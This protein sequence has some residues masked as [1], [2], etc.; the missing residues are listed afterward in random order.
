MIT[1]VFFMH[2]FYLIKLFIYLFISFHNCKNKREIQKILYIYRVFLLHQ[3]PS[4]EKPTQHLQGKMRVCWMTAPLGSSCN[5]LS[6]L[7]SR[8][9]RFPSGCGDV[10]L[11][12][13][14]E[15]VWRHGRRDWKTCVWTRP[16]MEEM[17]DENNKHIV[18]CPH[19]S[20]YYLSIDC[21]C[22]HD[23]QE[24]RKLI[25]QIQ[26]HAQKRAV[27]KFMVSAWT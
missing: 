16:E 17:K 23:F 8:G 14:C 27:W 9:C 3:T 7:S 20:Y 5:S 2:C 4:A 15:V 19:S 26:F 24:Y 22:D 1:C 21:L 6:H 18:F 13:L 12:R 10:L 11:R 25:P